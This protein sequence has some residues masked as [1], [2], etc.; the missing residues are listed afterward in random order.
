MTQKQA[1]ALIGM[2]HR[3]WQDWERGEG[4]AV[5]HLADIEE[6]LD[7]PRDYFVSKLTVLER[8][9]VFESRLERI[10]EKLDQSSELMRDIYGLLRIKS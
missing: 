9:V 5:A 4:D 2:S 7:L 3:S 8:L 10:E 1:A 6:A